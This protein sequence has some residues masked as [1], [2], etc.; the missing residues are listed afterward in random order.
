MLS[1]AKNSDVASKIIAVL[2][3]AKAPVDIASLW[4]QV[5]SDLVTIS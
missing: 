1:E 3:E 2:N 5:Q 4:A